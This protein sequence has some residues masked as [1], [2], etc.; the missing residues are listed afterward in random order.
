MKRWLV[1][2][3]MAAAALGTLVW[4]IPAAWV[5]PL[6]QTQWREVRME[7]ISGTLWKGQARKVSVG[8]GV[9]LGHLGWVLSRRALWGDLQARVELRQPQWQLYGQLQRISSGEFNLRDVS[10]HMNMALLGAP[11]WLKGQPRGQLDLEVPQ[12]QLRS[13]WP[14]RLEAMGRWTQAAI[15][16][17]HGRIPLG[18]LRLETAGQYGVWQGTFSDDGS[19]AVEASGHLFLSV[20]GWELQV[21]LMPRHEDPA[22]SNWLRSLGAPAADG[23]LELRY[24][25]VLT[26]S[27]Y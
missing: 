11:S 9:L 18:T 17:A 23:A 26:T 2:S 3:G 5:L 6:L 27:G 22:V 25:G 24:R 10:L 1:I 21:R 8:D 16:T 20:L 14:M 15:H 12:A 13:F 7:G 19:G 4:C